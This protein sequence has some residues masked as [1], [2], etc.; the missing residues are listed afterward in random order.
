MTG[1]LLVTTGFFIN[2]FFALLIIRGVYYPKQRDH[3]FIFTFLVFNSVIYIVMG[4]FTS[5]ELSIGVGF[6]LFALFSILRYRTE[7]IPI[8]EMTYLF[9]MVAMPMVN[10]FFFQNGQYQNLVI[11]NILILVITWI[12]EKGWGFSYEGH[13]QVIYE[14]IDLIN[15]SRRDEMIKD[16]IERT[17]L[18]VNRVEVTAIDYLRDTADVTIYYPLN[19]KYEK[20]DEV[21]KN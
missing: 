3:N 5:V 1:I 14:R 4:L 20:I 11:S 21:I 9:V 19:K 10:A 12:L 2:L 6:G 15:E 16:L 13:K 7:T 18:Q 8:R 17:G